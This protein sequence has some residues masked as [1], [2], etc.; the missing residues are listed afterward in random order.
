MSSWTVRYWT[1]I[2]WT[3]EMQEKGEELGLRLGLWLVLVDLGLA[4]VWLGLGCK[5]RKVRVWK[6]L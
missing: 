4:F 2:S 1:G 5:I 6:N 3:W